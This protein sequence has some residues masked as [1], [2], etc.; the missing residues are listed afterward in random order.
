MK[1]FTVRLTEDLAVPTVCLSQVQQLEA[2]A[3]QQKAVEL[4]TKL[5]SVL[6]DNENHCQHITVLEKE[7]EGY[8]IHMYRGSAGP[9][10]GGQFP[11]P[12][13]S[14]TGAPSPSGRPTY[15]SFG[16]RGASPRGGP[17]YSPHSPGYFPGSHRGFSE[18]P[19][20]RPRWFG[21]SPAGF[22]FRGKQRRGSNGFWGPRSYSPASAHGFQGRASDHSDSIEKYFSPAMLQDPWA[23]M[24]PVPVPANACNRTED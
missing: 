20:A 16:P 10:P 24:K 5:S 14:Y 2:F 1:D 18:A 13:W 21:N 23:G 8:S 6:Q 22:G 15:G 12:S 3:H 17:R 4:Q 7:L 19:P 11:S 9:W